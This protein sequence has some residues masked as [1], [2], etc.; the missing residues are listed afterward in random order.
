MTIRPALPDDVPAVLPLV[1]RTCAFHEQLNPARYP[2]KPQAEPMYRRWLGE[3]ATD[4]R[5]AFFV[6]EREGNIVAFI[7]GGVEQ[8]IPIYRLSEYG[9]LYDLW[10]EPEYRHEGIA[11][12][13]VMLA[14]ERYREIGVK[15]VRLEVSEGN[16]A[17]KALFLSC[18][19]K[20]STTEMLV[21]LATP[22]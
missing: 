6:A 12:Q 19:L 16:T 20:P 3:R 1:A 18:G 11:R 22:S 5:S 14:I 2:F 10:V 4:P 17:A 8:E 21:E 13:L 9:Y 7:V 15:Q